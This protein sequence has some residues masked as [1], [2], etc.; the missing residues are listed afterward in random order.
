[1]EHATEI[2]SITS[3][4]Q[5]SRLK[6]AVA[7]VAI[8]ILL[9]IIARPS[10][11]SATA[12]TQKEALKKVTNDTLQ[13]CRVILDGASSNKW[14]NTVRLRYLERVTGS[15]MALK[16]IILTQENNNDQQ[17]PD[18]KRLHNATR[19]L[20][21]ECEFLKKKIQQNDRKQKPRAIV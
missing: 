12:P 7:V 9:S 11:R 4:Q 8:V 5:A 14:E 10:W 15:L 21:A 18:C 3:K 17:D 16:Q 13:Q 19:K 20:V 2:V 6:L 1:M